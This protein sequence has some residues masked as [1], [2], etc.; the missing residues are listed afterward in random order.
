MVGGRVG[1][2]VWG[3]DWG[4]N[5]GLSSAIFARTCRLTSVTHMVTLAG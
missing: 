5:E 4:C 2:E 1:G 3:C